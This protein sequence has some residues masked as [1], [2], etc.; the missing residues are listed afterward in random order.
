MSLLELL[1]FL[2]PKKY[3]RTN[4]SSIFLSM[5]ERE[6][7]KKLKAHL[8]FSISFRF[9]FI[10]KHV[11]RLVKVFASCKLHSCTDSVH[12][13]N[14][15]MGYRYAHISVLR[16][17][18]FLFSSFNLHKTDGTSYQNGQNQSNHK[19]VYK[20]SWCIYATYFSIAKLNVIWKRQR[21]CVT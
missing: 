1:W 20:I 9:I 14:Y 5:V 8:W 19:S 13:S 12:C 15:R 11:L 18:S 3:L 4:I 17:I 16:A 2:R 7:L 6:C 10:T 21:T